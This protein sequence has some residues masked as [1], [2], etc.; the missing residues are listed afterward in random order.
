MAVET[1]DAPP[2]RRRGMSL[3]KGPVALIGV[4]SLALGVLG[5]IFASTDFTTHA[6]TGTVNGG[7]FI[8]IE[9]NGWTWVGFAAG[10]LL[11]LLG[12]PLHWGAK[13]TAFLVGLAYGVGA[14][15]ALSDGTDILGIFATNGWTKIVLGAAGVAL[16][17]LSMLP[18]VGR[19]APATAPAATTAGGRFR[20]RRTVER[21]PVGAAPGTTPNNGALDDRV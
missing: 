18:R 4:A 12:S 16:V 8:G 14:L 3:A 10:G 7:T 9:G 17:L 13:S 2:P 19:G 15:I 11:L 1:Y 20:H 6:P 21:E 5:L